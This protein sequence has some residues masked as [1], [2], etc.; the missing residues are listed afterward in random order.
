M[1]N[2]HGN[3]NL[4]RSLASWAMWKIDQ[5]DYTPQKKK[6][7]Q[8][9]ASQSAKSYPG[10]AAD[11]LQLSVS[12]R[13]NPGKRTWLPGK[14]KNRCHN[15]EDVSPIRKVGDFSSRP[16][17]VFWGGYRFIWSPCICQEYKKSLDISC[18]MKCYSTI[19][20]QKKLVYRIP[21]NDGCLRTQQSTLPSNLL[22]IPNTNWIT[23]FWR[24]LEVQSS[25]A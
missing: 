24:F 13:R 12:P 22:G 5:R 16:M 14:R 7:C 1:L 8:K 11:H 4:K 6:T 10:W 23:A 2:S 19:C 9:T 20:L 3:G 21:T 25:S 18:S 17:L 15:F